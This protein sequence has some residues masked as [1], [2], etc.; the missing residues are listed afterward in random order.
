MN[1]DERRRRPRGRIRVFGDALY[2]VLRFIARHVRGFYTAVITYLSFAFFIAV[3]AVWAFVAIATEMLEGST[4]RMDDAILTWVDTHR[5][6]VLDQVALDITALGN[7]A[8]LAVLVLTVAV[9][10]WLTRHRL[11]VALLVIAVAGGA[12]LNTLLKEIFDRPR[13]T[14]IEWGTEVH[15][16]SFPSGHAMAAAVAYGS[17]AYLGGRLEPTPTL[18]WTTYT[19]A[20]LLILA[21]G[22]SRVYLGVH[23]PSDVLAGWVAGLAWTGFVI[24]GLAAVRYFSRR[25]PELV[26]EEKDLHAEEERDKGLRA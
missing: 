14:V 11:S 7:T 5:T 19:F 15:T 17:V 21:V 3:G 2:G 20:A 12:V 8:T 10:L 4:Q 1:N 9:F 23:Y 26:E 16:Y 25:R 24:S 18:R 22:S 13:P 6:S